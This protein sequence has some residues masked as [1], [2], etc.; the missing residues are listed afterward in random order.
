MSK[1]LRWIASALMLLICMAA[2][3]WKDETTES[4]AR[5]GMRRAL[6]MHAISRGLN[7]V[8]S[9]AQGTR[10]QVQMGLGA[11][12]AVGEALQPIHDMIEQFAAA[13]LAAAAVF[14]LQLLLIKLGSSMLLNSV[15]TLAA[16]A[17][18]ALWLWRGSVPRI[19]L[20]VLALLLLLRFAV[21]VSVVASGWT[22]E[23]LLKQDYDTSVQQLK[24]TDTYRRSETLQP[25]DFQAS[26]RPDSD[27]TPATASKTSVL[28][29][30]FSPF[31][32]A[33]ESVK[34]AAASVGSMREDLLRNADSL[35]ESMVNLAVQF[36]LQTLVLPL[37]FGAAL[38]SITRVLMRSLL[39][40]GKA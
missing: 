11:E 40:G 18:L 17:T 19:S 3:T 4:Q 21:P 27:G 6:E 2:W 28:S 7:A 25:A 16:A 30:L 31:Q 38:V 26:K 37:L 22:R 13:M 23:Q 12:L 14:G 36:L 34:D 1:N 9:V 5:D 15:L 20:H 35:A 33:L 8:V 29:S 10:V 39:A 24:G 32:K